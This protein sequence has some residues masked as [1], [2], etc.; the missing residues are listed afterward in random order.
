MTSK[1][2]AT[3]LSILFS[4]YAMAQ[5]AY[6]ESDLLNAASCPR[7]VFL[8]D[9]GRQG[10]F[11][12][13]KAS[14]PIL[15]LPE[16]L[17]AKL[18]ISCQATTYY[19]AIDLNGDWDVRWFGAKESLA[20][21]APIFNLVLPNLKEWQ[22]LKVPRG[23]YKFLSPITVAHGNLHADAL[24][25]FRSSSG[26][27]VRGNKRVYVYQ[28]FGGNTEGDPHNT[29][30][31]TGLSLIN[32]GYSFVH[33]HYITG[34]DTGIK[35]SGEGL[36]GTQYA[37]IEFA[38]LVNNNVG[39]LLTTEGDNQK[40]WS[41]ENSYYGGRIE[42]VTGIKSV[43]ALGQIDEF[44]NNKFYNIGFE[45]LDVGLDLNSFKMN[46]FFAPRFEDTPK[47]IVFHDS[48]SRHNS[49]ISSRIQESDFFYKGVG[50]RAAPGTVVLG[51]LLGSF[52]DARMAGMISSTS[53]TTP[54]TFDG[55]FTTIRV[56]NVGKTTNDNFEGKIA[57]MTTLAQ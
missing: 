9:P 49:F 17:R 41:N 29:G 13:P 24:L 50:H 51:P 14:D 34:F 57:P 1:Y 15:S 44:N 27:T 36:N 7:S 10:V 5:E 30:F 6:S 12:V 18:R 4:S 47:P 45:G 20:D 2:I 8:T 39:I 23:T 3:L 35:V 25:W 16:G 52:S 54:D 19:R 22:T 38:R 33:V 28:I 32:A 42:G 21:N 11:Y 43:L 46:Y 56:D 37:R 55:S 40:N 31:G 48:I 53:D 26:I